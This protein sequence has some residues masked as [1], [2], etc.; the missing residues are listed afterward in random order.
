MEVTHNGA[1]LPMFVPCHEPRCPERMRLEGH[2]VG[3]PVYRCM[4]RVGYKGKNEVYGWNCHYHENPYSADEY[5]YWHKDI[6]GKIRPNPDSK[7]DW[8]VAL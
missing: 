1:R 8:K 4:R 2:E 6:K 3:N 5:A 7:E